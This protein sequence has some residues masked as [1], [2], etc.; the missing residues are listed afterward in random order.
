VRARAPTTILNEDGEEIDLAETLTVS[1]ETVAL[2]LSG[3]RA[4]V[5]EQR[6]GIQDREEE[7]EERTVQVVAGDVG[8]IGVGFPSKVLVFG[9]GFLP[10][11]EAVAIDFT[12]I[13]L[14]E[15]ETE[16]EGDEDSSETTGRRRRL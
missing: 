5:Q 8:E 1:A 14:E 13:P 2:D 16:A 7:E 9:D 11:P 12:P 4:W 10:G 3:L 6:L 15:L